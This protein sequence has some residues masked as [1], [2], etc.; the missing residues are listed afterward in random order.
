MRIVAGK[1]RGRRLQAPRDQSIRPTT[2][3]NRESLFNVLSHNWPEHLRGK[4]LDVFAGTGALG[5]E[6]LSRGSS[7]CVFVEKNRQGLSL[8]EEHVASFGLADQARIVRADATRPGVADPWAPFDLIFADPPYGRGLGEKAMAALAEKGWF[9]KGAII[10]L[11]EKRGCLPDAST[12]F[13]KL[14]QRDSGD[15]SIGIYKYVTG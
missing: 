11:E 3:R 13:E 6:A 4:V 12:R 14:D 8:I 2:D 15:T 9:A 5:L 1:F 10:V 7:H